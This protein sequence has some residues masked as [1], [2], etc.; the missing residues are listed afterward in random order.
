MEHEN[1][2]SSG[3][4]YR[5]NTPVFPESERM[6][7]FYGEAHRIIEDNFARAREKSVGGMMIADYAVYED[8]DGIVEVTLRMRMRICGK[9]AWEKSV[10]HRWRDGYIAPERRRRKSRP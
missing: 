5:I 10:S 2:T 7:G 1:R 3:A 9:I 6:S 8:A 4:G